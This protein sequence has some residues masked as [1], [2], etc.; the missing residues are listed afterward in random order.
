MDYS[1]GTDHYYLPERKIDHEYS[2]R[3]CDSNA[4]LLEQKTGNKERRAAEVETSSDMVFA[5]VPEDI[6]IIRLDGPIVRHE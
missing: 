3:E 2:L 6:G 4:Q 5:P 1:I